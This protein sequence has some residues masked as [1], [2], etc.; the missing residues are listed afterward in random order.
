MAFEIGL[1]PEKETGSG[2]RFPRCVTVPDEVFSALRDGRRRFVIKGYDE[3]N[4]TK[5]MRSPLTHLYVNRHTDRGGRTLLFAVEGVSKIALQ[6][7]AGWR[8]YIRIELLDGR[9]VR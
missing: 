3:W 8:D 4:E 9:E 5:F 1:H 2:R 6:T 7:R